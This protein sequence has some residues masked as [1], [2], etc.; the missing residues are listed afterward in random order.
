M[1]LIDFILNV[2]ALLLWLNRRSLR[3]DPLVRTRPVTLIGTLRR[4]EP[5]RLGRWQLGITLAL[6][7]LFRAL[8]YW[9][10]SRIG[11]PTG[12]TPRLGLG[13]I[14]LA[15]RGDSFWAEVVFSALSFLQVLVIFYFCLVALAIINRKTGGSDPI[16]KLVRL[17]LGRLG[18]WPWPVQ[19]VLPLLVVAGLWIAL[20]P[21]LLHLDVLSRTPATWHLVKQ[22]L[23]VGGWLYFTLEYLLPPFLF[24]Q[25]ILNYVYLGASPVW[26]FISLTASN[27]MLPL[28]RLPL[29]F[30]RLDF[31]PVVGVI[32][33]YL[34]L[35]WLPESILGEMA[36]RNV[37]LWPQ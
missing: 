20:H 34:L 12:W 9:F 24:A 5:R 15:F 4:A 1:T 16:Q 22:G 26:D 6:L 35:H 27:V 30:G 28:R 13:L 18:L 2:A 36:R 32:L 29:R 7:L 19:A 21:V 23:L 33:L 14:V 17:H 3:F 8:F 11:S 31:T 10:Y 37:A 25:L